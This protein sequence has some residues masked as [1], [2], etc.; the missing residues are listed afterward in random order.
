MKLVFA[1]PII[2]IRPRVRFCEASFLTLPNS[3]STWLRR[4]HD[5]HQSRDPNASGCQ[6]GRSA[7]GVRTVCCTQI[8]CSSR[9]R[10]TWA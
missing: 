4:F 7:A 6:N 10:L 2:R 8:A 9:F 3:P 1:N 5:F